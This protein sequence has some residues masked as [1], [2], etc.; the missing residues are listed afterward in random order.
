M[1]RLSEKLQEEAKQEAIAESKNNRQHTEA[2]EALIKGL[3]KNLEKQTDVLRD[4]K[5]RVSS[6]DEYSLVWQLE[7]RL[8]D[9][10]FA[11]KYAGLVVPAIR[12]LER[13]LTDKRDQTM[14]EI[15]SGL[16]DRV[17][18]LT[19][20][21]L[22]DDSYRHNSTRESDSI[23]NRQEFRA[24]QS[25]CRLFTQAVEAFNHDMTAD[26]DKG[27]LHGGYISDYRY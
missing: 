18:E 21:L 4:I 14:C 22:N 26:S 19:R 7:A 24:C 17:S 16:E 10:F 9:M 1:H 8:D 23:K 27:V 12:H 15:V 6:S 11:N 13:Q 3:Q 25:V 20:T 5:D 2:I